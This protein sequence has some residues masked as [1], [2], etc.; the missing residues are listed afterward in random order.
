MT[1][2]D[3]TMYLEDLIRMGFVSEHMGEEGQLYYKLTDLGVKSGLE[4]FQ[5]SN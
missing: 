1:L 5:N 2:G 4:D 3:L